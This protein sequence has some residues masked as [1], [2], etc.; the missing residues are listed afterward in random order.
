MPRCQH[1]HGA[2]H[3]AAIATEQAFGEVPARRLKKTLVQAST[4]PER[5][6]QLLQRVGEYTATPH[7]LS[8]ARDILGHHLGRIR[9]APD[10]DSTSATQRECAPC[11]KAWHG[12]PDHATASKNY[13]SRSTRAPSR[14][15]SPCC[16]VRTESGDTVHVLA[17]P[18]SQ[19]RAAETKARKLEAKA[20][21][22]SSRSPRA[23]APRATKEA[24][25]RAPP[26]RSTSSPLSTSQRKTNV[27]NHQ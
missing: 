19:N 25:P 2:T 5:T 15:T 12:E 27:E 6:A 8:V 18:Q 11:K 4:D 20:R 9:D 1:R 26:H 16:E 14:R 23:C 3:A 22:C 24:P 13:T 10:T 21:S 17:R 7:D